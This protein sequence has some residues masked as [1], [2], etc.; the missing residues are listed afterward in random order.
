MQRG[1]QSLIWPKPRSDLLSA[2]RVLGNLRAARYPT[3]QAKETGQDVYAKDG[4]DELPG[5][6]HKLAVV[7]ALGRSGDKDNPGLRQGH[8]GAESAA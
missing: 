1:Y 8:L 5:G 6:P 2:V 4:A 7:G 3:E